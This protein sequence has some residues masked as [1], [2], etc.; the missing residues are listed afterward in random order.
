MT[1]PDRIARTGEQSIVAVTAL[2]TSFRAGAGLFPK[3]AVAAAL[4]A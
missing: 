4:C 2:K 3:S 1:A